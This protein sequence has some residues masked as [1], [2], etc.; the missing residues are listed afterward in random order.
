M[1]RIVKLILIS[2]LCVGLMPDGCSKSP[3]VIEYSYDD[4]IRSFILDSETGQTLFSPNLYSTE[5]FLFGDSGQ[6]CFYGFDSTKRSIN[7]AIAKRPKDIPPYNGIYDALAAVTDKYFG[8]LMRINGIDTT[9][10]YEM[11]NSIVRYGYFIKPFDDWYPYRGW[12]FWGFVGGKYSSEL[13]SGNRF[14][15]G[16]DGMTMPALPPQGEPP[17]INSQSNSGYYI[18]FDDVKKFTRGD[19]ITLHSRE[20]DLIFVETAPGIIKPLTTIP[21]GNNYRAGWMVSSETNKLY[22]L[23]LFDRA[24]YFVVDT[25]GQIIESTL[26]KTDDYLIPFGVKL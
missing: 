4:M 26:I 18:N 19:S 5:S 24:G 20:K 10:A 17:A 25:I 6:L 12:E 22:H 23:L 14:I 16:S 15:M 2:I 3:S 13:P 11:Q 21:D 7:I 9:L 8:K 1:S